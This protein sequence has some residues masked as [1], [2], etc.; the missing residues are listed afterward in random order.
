VYNPLGE[1]MAILENSD[2]FPGR[3][4]YQWNAD[5][6]PGGVYFYR[7]EVN[8]NSITKNLVLVK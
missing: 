4:S 8:G 2:L 7:L 6:F 3:Y 1:E 5:N